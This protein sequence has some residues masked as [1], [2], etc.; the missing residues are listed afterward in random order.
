[1]RNAT[2]IGLNISRLANTHKTEP[3]ELIASQSAYILTEDQIS[4]FISSKSF[5]SSTYFLSIDD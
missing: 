3:T 5:H 4:I 1:M 2:C